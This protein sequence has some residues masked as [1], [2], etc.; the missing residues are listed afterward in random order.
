VEAKSRAAGFDA[1]LVKPADPEAL[2][3]LLTGD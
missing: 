2:R 1:L 3:R